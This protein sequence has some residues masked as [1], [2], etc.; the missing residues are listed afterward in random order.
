MKHS[1]NKKPETFTLPNGEQIGWTDTIYAQFID[2]CK[3]LGS[4]VVGGLNRVFTS[5]HSLSRED[6]EHV[7]RLHNKAWQKKILRWYFSRFRDISR[8]KLEEIYHAIEAFPTN[9]WTDKDWAVFG[10]LAPKPTTQD[11][12]LFKNNSHPANRTRKI[13]SFRDIQAEIS[14]NYDEVDGRGHR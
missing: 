4:D 14:G 6:M 9:N 11:K 7:L 3:N 8:D 10:E 2:T 1:S 12:K 5:K 13:P